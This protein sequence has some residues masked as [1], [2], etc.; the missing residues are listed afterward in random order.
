[1]RL[2]K[3]AHVAGPLVIAV[4]LATFAAAGEAPA[5]GQTG[6][7]Q[8]RKF[9][10]FTIGHGSPNR[11]ICGVAESEEK[12]L[13]RRL[14]RYAAQLRKERALPY[15]ISYS[16]R[17]VEHEVYDRS[18]ASMR[19]SSLLELTGLGFDYRRITAV[20]GGFREV[21]TTE[22]WIVP[23]GAAPPVPSPTVE[24]DRVARCPKVYANGQR[25][26]AKPTSPLTFH[27]LLQTND[28]TAVLT[29]E[30]RVSAGT[31]VGGQGTREI[32]VEVPA[33]FAGE[34]VAKVDV[35]GC[36]LECPPGEIA[37]IARTEVG[38]SRLRYHAWET[39]GC[40]TDSAVLDDVAVVLMSNPSL[41]AHVVV[42]GGRS[43]PK[44]KA[45]ARA[46]RIRNYLV[47]EK[48]LDAERVIALDGGFRNE[49]F[50]EVWISE[51]GTDAPPTRSTVDPAY[52]RP[53]GR[54]APKAEPCDY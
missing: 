16:P 24:P 20:D 7:P 51:R 42:Y 37:S 8:A 2:E 39:T 40:E 11:W 15:A 17:V 1:M 41:Q 52:V 5:H 26:V 49:L 18:I 46:G 44:N 14:A 25:F 35:L 29:F 3:I 43:D 23:P 38:T 47:L 50:A 4:A 32:K 53:V 31:I 19:N 13:K 28:S 6:G 48:G 45:L 30:W 22:L 34:V 33:G 10:E 12:E 36:S 27:A 54:L 9:D 21:A